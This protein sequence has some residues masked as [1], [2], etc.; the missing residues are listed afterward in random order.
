MHAAAGIAA[1][2]DGRAVHRRHAHTPVRGQSL[3]KLLCRARP[4]FCVRSWREVRVTNSPQRLQ[5]GVVHTPRTRPLRA[6]NA[7]GGWIGAERQLRI[8]GLSGFETSISRGLVFSS[9]S[10]DFGGA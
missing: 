1:G 7:F 8:A 4:D 9:I 6:A 2:R 10:G 3:T 5:E